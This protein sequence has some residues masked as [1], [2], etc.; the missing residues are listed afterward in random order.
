VRSGPKKK[1]PITKKGKEKYND[2]QK[3]K[4]K[5]TVMNLI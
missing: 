3:L 1:Q 5:W 2:Q 4:K